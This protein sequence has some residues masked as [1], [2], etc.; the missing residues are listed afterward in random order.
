MKLVEK[1]K[2][3]SL[4]EASIKLLVMRVAGAALFEVV[5]KAIF[6]KLVVAEKVIVSL[7]VLIRDEVIVV[8]GEE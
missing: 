1:V 3:E 7:E 2:V 4:V 5:E 6:V 8:L